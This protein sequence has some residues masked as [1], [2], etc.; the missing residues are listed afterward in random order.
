MHIN[1]NGSPSKA[2]SIGHTEPL[3]VTLNNRITFKYSF[4]IIDFN[5]LMAVK[6]NVL[7]GESICSPSQASI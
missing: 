1:K 7:L 5:N 3:K 6:F 2:E 4:E